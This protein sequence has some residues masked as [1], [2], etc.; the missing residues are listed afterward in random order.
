[1]SLKKIKKIEKIK[2]NEKIVAIIFILFLTCTDVFTQEADQNQGQDQYVNG[3]LP[4]KTIF[5]DMGWNF[6]HSFTDNYGSF[7]IAGTAVTFAF[8]ETGLDWEFRNIMYNNQDI[9]ALGNPALYIG[10]GVPFILPL[11][12]Y[13][14]GIRK[15]NEKLQVAAFAIAQ[16]TLLTAGTMSVFKMVSGRSIPGIADE[17]DHSRNH[18]TQ[19]FSGKFD[20]FNMNFI[21]GWPSAHTAQA[22][23]TAAALSQIYYDNTAVK[24]A[25]YSY[26]AFIGIGVSLNVHWASDVIAGA[27]MG[28]A[29]GYTVG[30]NFNKLLKNS[31]KNDDTTL[32]F[33]ASPASLGVVIRL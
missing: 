14:S 10:Y 6:L 16:T 25:A 24:I 12:L 21:A 3:R 19:D 15:K 5:H 22:F 1:M 17:F 8:I 11:A 2:K 20:W 29:I 32:S 9:A 26:A 33:Y 23:A 7:F 28:Y 30:R 13:F 18:S 31:N 27:L 4:L